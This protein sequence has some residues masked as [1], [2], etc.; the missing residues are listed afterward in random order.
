[1]NSQLQKYARNE[2]KAGLA[3]LPE[4][5]RMLFTRMYSH[6]NLG[7]DIN[8]IIDAMPEDKLDW[9]MQQVQRSMEK[10]KEDG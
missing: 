5:H 9:A 2:L 7:A 8:D 6:K 10:I 3:K 1:M 4:N